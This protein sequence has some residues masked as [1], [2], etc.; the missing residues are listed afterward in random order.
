[1]WKW[2]C[3]GR[4]DA[5]LDL[6]YLWLSQ[7]VRCFYVLTQCSFL[8]LCI[9]KGFASQQWNA[10]YFFLCSLLLKCCGLHLS[11]PDKPKSY[12]LLCWLLVLTG[13]TV[14]SPGNIP[15]WLQ[16]EPDPMH[17]GIF[18]GPGSVHEIPAG[19]HELW[20]GPALTLA[21]VTLPSLCVTPVPPCF[22]VFCV[23]LKQCNKG[24]DFPSCGEASAQVLLGFPNTLGS[25]APSKIPALSS[26]TI[27]ENFS[28]RHFQM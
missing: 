12:P 2:V 18:G 23:W 16:C 17:S 5:Q 3:E 24:W 11:A 9:W 22:H 7:T 19:F 26:S 6:F 28:V 27:L 21:G 15:V 4:K 20:M 1:M 10:A 13:S 14:C 25:W 8:D